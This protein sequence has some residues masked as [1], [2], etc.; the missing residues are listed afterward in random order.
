MNYL[1]K[2]K[3]KLGDYPMQNEIYAKKYFLNN[4]CLTNT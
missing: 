1:N 4:K 2:A 3:V